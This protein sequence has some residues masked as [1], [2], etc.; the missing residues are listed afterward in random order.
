M[1]EKK[2][3]SEKSSKVNV[4][5]YLEQVRATSLQVD[6]KPTNKVYKGCSLRCIQK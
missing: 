1:G 2:K 3:K 4:K 5:E 6:K